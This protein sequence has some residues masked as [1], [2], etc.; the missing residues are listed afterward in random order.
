M[1]K[2]CGFIEWIYSR[3]KV[4]IAEAKNLYGVNYRMVVFSPKEDSGIY[5]SL[6]DP[7]STVSNFYCYKSSKIFNAVTHGKSL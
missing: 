1:T 5:K 7:A 3:E 6:F 2:V 4:R